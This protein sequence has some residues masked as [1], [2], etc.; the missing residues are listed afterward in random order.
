MASGF[1]CVTGPSH[2]E[3]GLEAHAHQRVER[4]V[5]DLHAMRLAQPLTQVFIGR[6]AL[7]AMERLCKTGED[8]RCEQDGF[9]SRDIGRQ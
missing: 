8:A 2:F 5:L 9:T 6:E 4:F 7:G 3:L 1:F